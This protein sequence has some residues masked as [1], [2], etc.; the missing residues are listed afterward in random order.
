MLRLE[1]RPLKARLSHFWLAMMALSRAHLG[2]WVMMAEILLTTILA[3]HA[4]LITLRK[5][6]ALGM[7]ILT[8]HRWPLSLH[9]TMHGS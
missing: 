2:P 1:T 8:M 5:A 4:L 3:L 9:V 6:K 7:M